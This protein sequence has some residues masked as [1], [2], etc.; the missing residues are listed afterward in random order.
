MAIRIRRGNQI[1]FEK[2]KLVQGEL[3]IVLDA[4]E[5]HFCYGA[6][7]TKRLATKEDLQEMLD[8]SETS[9]S[10]LI[11]LIADLETN[12]DELTNILNNISALQ[13]D[14]IDTTEKGVTI[15]TLVDGKVP[16]E[17]LPPISSSASD[18]TYDNTE[19]GLVAEDVQGAIDEVGSQ[20]AETPRVTTA[21]LTIYVDAINGSDNNNG[22]ELTP[23]QT[24]QKA[25]DSIPTNTTKEV[26]IQLAEGTY[27]SQGGMDEWGRPVLVNFFEKLIN[28]KRDDN[29]AVNTKGA[30]I[31]IKGAGK[32]LTVLDG[33]VIGARVGI[34]GHNVKNIFL[35]D[36]KII[37]CHTAVLA[38]EGG[39][40]SILRIGVSENVNGISIESNSR[41][42]IGY[43]DI[44]NNDYNVYMKNGQ[45]QMNNCKVDNGNVNNFKLEGS[46][47][48]LTDTINSK[49]L[50]SKICIDAKGVG[51]WNMKVCDFEG[52]TG[53]TFLKGSIQHLQISQETHIHG[54][55]SSVF[56]PNSGFIHCIGVH[57]WGNGFVIYATEGNPYIKMDNCDSKNKDNIDEPNTQ[58]TPMRMNCSGTLHTTGTTILPYKITYTPPDDAIMLFGSAPPTTGFH[59]KGKVMF[60]T[61]VAIGQ[62]IGWQCTVA[63]AP[64]T[65]V[66][67]PSLA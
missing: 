5:L 14:K 7:N 52:S 8:M 11:Q 67:L 1:D 42:E 3:A 22:S 53:S 27:T 24:I 51:Y 50:A 64:G 30:K 56:V 32:E 63:G 34:Y 65:W 46:N 41:I 39:D 26:L 36:L 38:H 23:F 6:G 13:S 54:F 31:K 10:A 20:L 9:Y 18:I 12:P 25:I 44:Y 58:G 62:P 47:Y 15:A 57:I 4:G 60:N 17:Q 48:V 2:N 59:F 43:S 33:S 16:S 37:G 40:I 21:N 61:A 66:P 19:S 49:T 55:G 28:P 35:E 45:L 29:L